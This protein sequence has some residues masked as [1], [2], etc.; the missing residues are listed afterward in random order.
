MTKRPGRQPIPGKSVSLTAEPDFKEYPGMAD[1]GV[2]YRRCD[3][4]YIYDQ[5]RAAVE[6][7]VADLRLRPGATADSTSTTT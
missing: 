1:D 6:V 5:L 4:V 7:E 3:E 2:R